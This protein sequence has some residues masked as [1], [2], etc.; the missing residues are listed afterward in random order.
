M[1]GRSGYS[2]LVFMVSYHDADGLNNPQVCSLLSLTP[3]KSQTFMPASVFDPVYGFRMTH[4][5]LRPLPLKPCLLKF[6]LSALKLFLLHFALSLLTLSHSPWGHAARSSLLPFSHKFC[7]PA[8]LLPIL[9]RRQRHPMQFPLSYIIISPS[10]CLAF[11]D[12]A[13]SSSGLGTPFLLEHPCSMLTDM[14]HS[15]HMLCILTEV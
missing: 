10:F 6:L 9:L 4:G 13:R 8:A 3:H 5:A 14:V 15:T 12:M 7:L 1:H 2:L 11:A